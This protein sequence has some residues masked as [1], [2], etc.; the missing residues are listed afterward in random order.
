MAKCWWHDYDRK[1]RIN[2]DRQFAA[3][4]S[5][6]LCAR[7]LAQSPRYSLLRVFFH[8]ELAIRRR[9][10]SFPFSLS[11]CMCR[12]MINRP[13][14]LITS[15]KT[16]GKTKESKK[17]NTT[18]KP[19]EQ[20]PQNEPDGQCF[21]LIYMET[22]DPFRMVDAPCSN[23]PCVRLFGCCSLAFRFLSHVSLL[24]LIIDSI[25]RCFLHTHFHR[26]TLA[27]C[28]FA[29]ISCLIFGS[30]LRWMCS[31]FC[32]LFTKCLRR[33]ATQINSMQKKNASPFVAPFVL[34]ET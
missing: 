14:A 26:Q 33:G 21:W 4:S 11:W 24:L 8:R 17:P 12:A 32:V 1:K 22:D 29:L 34:L 6:V 7:A 15:T 5:D 18:A 30:N 20:K 16:Q 25:V 27:N 2:A 28:P 3:R 10:V 31:V 19:K 23:G 13:F 9:T